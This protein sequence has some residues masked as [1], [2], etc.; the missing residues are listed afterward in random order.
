MAK[1]LYR[2]LYD[3]EKGFA[4]EQH[5]DEIGSAPDRVGFVTTAETAQYL[6]VRKVALQRDGRDPFDDSRMGSRDSVYIVPVEGD[7]LNP[8]VYFV[9]TKPGERGGF[10]LTCGTVD[11][12]GQNFTA[13]NTDQNDLVTFFQLQTAI[14]SLPFPG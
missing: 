4:V 11:T 3:D 7:A 12:N 6:G 14:T 5:I 9:V 1:I 10:H 13:W 8:V 2:I